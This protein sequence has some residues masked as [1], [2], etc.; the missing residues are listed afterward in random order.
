MLALHSET[1][2]DRPEI[3]KTTRLSPISEVVRQ[4]PPETAVNHHKLDDNHNDTASNTNQRIQE[5][6]NKQLTDVASQTSPPKWF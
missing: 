1:A 2:Y 6:E 4:Q 3:D 5:V